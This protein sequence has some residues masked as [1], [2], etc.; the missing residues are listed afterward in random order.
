MALEQFHFLITAFCL[1]VWT[2]APALTVAIG[3]AFQAVAFVAGIAAPDLDEY[4]FWSFLST[5]LGALLGVGLLVVTRAPRFLRL[6]G[7][8]VGVWG[9]FVVWLVFFLAAQLFY[10]FFPPS[11]QEPWGV[12]GTGISHLV[13]QVVL[14]VVMFYST[15][16]FTYYGGGGQLVGSD[17]AKSVVQYAG[18]TYLFLTW[19][20]SLVVAEF[21]FFLAYVIAER[22]AALVAFGGAAA[23]LV[24]AGLLFPIRAPYVT[25]SPLAGDPLIVQRGS[26]S[27]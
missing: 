3:W 21:L 5:L 10:G 19:I 1:T 14:W 15:S 23:V 4:I 25:A 26:G 27:V 12:I 22:Y 17:Q 8:Y 2:H 11:R 6:E 16:V 13:V 18:R 9:Q 7:S 20:V 24:V